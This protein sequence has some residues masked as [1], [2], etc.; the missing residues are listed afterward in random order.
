MAAFREVSGF[1]ALEDH[2]T[3]SVIKECGMCPAGGRSSRT[4]NLNNR[5]SYAFVEDSARCRHLRRLN[6]TS[7]TRRM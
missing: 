4:R 6:S 2:D 5:F 3:V 1:P 7:E